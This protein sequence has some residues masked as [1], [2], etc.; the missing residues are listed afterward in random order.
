MHR[1]EV[2]FICLMST[3]S[4]KDFSSFAFTTKWF[5]SAHG[6]TT[7][8]QQKENKKK[9][10]NSPARVEWD[11]S[12]E[13]FFMKQK[14]FL[15]LFLALCFEAFQRQQ[16]FRVARGMELKALRVSA[17]CLPFVNARRDKNK[18]FLLHFFWFHLPPPSRK[19]NN[20]ICFRELTQRKRFCFHNFTYS[21][22]PALP[23]RAFNA[24]R[25]SI[26]FKCVR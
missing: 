25:R 15:L 24:K 23:F 8:Q 14:H 7:Q 2:N 10:K 20:L 4:I 18:L 1:A 17:F 19:H 16:L 9:V 21:T 6:I 3:Q 26:K 5:K 22:H 13:I 12:G 11:M